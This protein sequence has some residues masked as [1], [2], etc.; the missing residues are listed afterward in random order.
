[1]HSNIFWV[2]GHCNKSL[3]QTE[4]TLY[5]KE[6]SASHILTVTQCTICYLNVAK[7]KMNIVVH[8]DWVGR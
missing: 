6:A 2:C 3:W 8:F 7:S 5:K 1:M 4:D